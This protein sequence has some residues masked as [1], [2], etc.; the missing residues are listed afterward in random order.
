MNRVTEKWLKT[1]KK[2]MVFARPVMY[3]GQV[4]Q[5]GRNVVT[6]GFKVLKRHHFDCKMPSRQNSRHTILFRSIHSMFLSSDD[7]GIKR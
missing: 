7:D 5:S 1:V 3:A 6:F 4:S 2:E